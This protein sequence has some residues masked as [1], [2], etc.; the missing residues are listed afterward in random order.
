MGGYG[1]GQRRRGHAPA[2]LGPRMASM[3]DASDVAG[4]SSVLPE[5]WCTISFATPAHAY[6]ECLISRKVD[7]S[8]APRMEPAGGLT[9]IGT[10]PSSATDALD[11]DP[12]QTTPPRCPGHGVRSGLQLSRGSSY[13]AG[14]AWAGARGTLTHW[15][16]AERRGSS[17]GRTLGRADAD[18][19]AVPGQRRARGGHGRPVAAIPK[20]RQLAGSGSREV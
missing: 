4:A 9:V 12:V 13:G 1:S 19:D 11:C 2:P 17:H 15:G 6:M 18:A 8:T 10:L 20:R 14:G 16:A 3:D 7:L 5:T